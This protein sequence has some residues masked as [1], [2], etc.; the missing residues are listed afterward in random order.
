MKTTMID[1]PKLFE[2]SLVL[3]QW[4]KTTTRAKMIK[5]E[6]ITFQTR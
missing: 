6:S 3:I 2:T 5:L 4:M 1:I